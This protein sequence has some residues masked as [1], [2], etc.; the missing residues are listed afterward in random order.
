MLLP[1][2]SRRLIAVGCVLAAGGYVL[3]H[4]SGRP[5][6]PA[7]VQLRALPQPKAADPIPLP[8]NLDL[9]PR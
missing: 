9:P 6:V 3:G 7:R 4:G 8:A 2:P 1:L 5:D